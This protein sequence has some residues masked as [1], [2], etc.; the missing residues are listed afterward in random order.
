MGALLGITRSVVATCHLFNLSFWRWRYT[1]Y[2]SDCTPGVLDRKVFP[3]KKN[4]G[5]LHHSVRNG[6][7]SPQKRLVVMNWTGFQPSRNG[8]LGILEARCQSGKSI[9]LLFRTSPLAKSRPHGRHD[10]PS[11]LAAS[12]HRNPRERSRFLRKGQ[13]SYHPTLINYLTVG[14]RT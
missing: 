11:S 10:K 3:D 12:F 9:R 8:C 5:L 6:V 7:M 4:R 2:S 1:R 14:F 13:V